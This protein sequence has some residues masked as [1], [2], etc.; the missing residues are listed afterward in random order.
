MEIKFPVLATEKI[1]IRPIDRKYTLNM[2][3]VFWINLESLTIYASWVK[4]KINNKNLSI[5]NYRIKPTKCY[6]WVFDRI[7][8]LTIW[9]YYYIYTLLWLNWNFVVRGWLKAKQFSNLSTFSKTA[10]PI[11]LKFTLLLYIGYLQY[12]N[13]LKQSGTPGGYTIDNYYS[14]W[15][16]I[17]WEA[18]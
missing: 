1:L 3:K 15:C 5:K 2:L 10:E 18:I 4:H 11:D 7:A 16:E 9:V 17:F 13:L 14:D 6:E 8:N 12:L